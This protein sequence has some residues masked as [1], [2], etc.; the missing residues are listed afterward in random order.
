MQTAIFVKQV[1]RDQGGIVCSFSHTFLGPLS[2]GIHLKFFVVLVKNL[3]HAT[4]SNGDNLANLGGGGSIII[5]SGAVLGHDASW[6]LVITK[7]QGRSGWELVTPCATS[8]VAV[9][10]EILKCKTE[11]CSRERGQQ[12]KDT[13]NCPIYE[14]QKGPHI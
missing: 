8:V 10:G 7:G 9:T 11:R 13:A 6:S 2:E 14:S 3:N 12:E 1:S 5:W 4:K